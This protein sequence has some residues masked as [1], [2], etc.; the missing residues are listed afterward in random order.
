MPDRITHVWTR[1]PGHQEAQDARAWTDA[2]REKGHPLRVL[3]Q[4]ILQLAGDVC[5]RRET[6]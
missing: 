2:A 6:H 4:E 5:R 1:L 3:W